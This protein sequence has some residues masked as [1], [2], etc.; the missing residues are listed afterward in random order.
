MDNFTEGC[1]EQRWVASVRI[2]TSMLP[3]TPNIS[4]IGPKAEAPCETGSYSCTTIG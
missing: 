4:A 1:R 3:A 2:K